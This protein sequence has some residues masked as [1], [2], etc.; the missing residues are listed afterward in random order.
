MKTRVDTD[1]KLYVLGFLFSKDRESI[2]L[3][4]KN[5]PEWQKGLFNGI[6]GKIEKGENPSDAMNRECEEECGLSDIDWKHYASLDGQDFKVFVFRAFIEN[7]WDVEQKESEKL[8]ISKIP[9]VSNKLVSNCEFLIPLA[10]S[11]N[12]QFP[13]ELKVI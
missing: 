4:E 2:L 11:T 6:G 9:V 12:I 7:I 5:I 8:L 13:I 10:L 3:I 1:L